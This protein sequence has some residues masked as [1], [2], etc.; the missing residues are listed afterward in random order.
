[1]QGFIS[2]KERNVPDSSNALALPS[3]FFSRSVSGELH[4]ERQSHS[5]FG[6]CSPKETLPYLSGRNPGWS[7]GYR[8]FYFTRRGLV[9]ST[10]SMQ[11]K[12]HPGGLQ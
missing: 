11:D 3:D 12:M 6:V 5:F 4:R 9:P 1:M 8:A 7:L 10:P 2:T